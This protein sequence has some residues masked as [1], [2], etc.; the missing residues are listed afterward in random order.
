MVELSSTLS[1]KLTLFPL[2]LFVVSLLQHPN[3]VPVG[4]KKFC[5][6]CLQFTYA[7]K[8]NT[9]GLWSI[10]VAG[11]A[12]FRHGTD[13]KV[14]T[15]SVPSVPSHLFFSFPFSFFRG[16]LESFLKQCEGRINDGLRAKMA[17]DMARGLAWLHKWNVIHRDFKSSNVMVSF[18]SSFVLA[19]LLTDMFP[20]LPLSLF[21][22]LK[23]VE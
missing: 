19:V 8:K 6:S 3:L 22:F 20:S 21:L 5:C 10:C 4:F 18:T 15:A 17:V 23:L 13:D 16:S 1:W 2:F 14:R 9:Q 11:V 7:Q 12:L